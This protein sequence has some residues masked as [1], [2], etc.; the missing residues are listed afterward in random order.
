MATAGV[1][2]TLK[3][4]LTSRLAPRGLLVLLPVLIAAG[5]GGIHRHPPEVIASLQAEQRVLT[6]KLPADRLRLSDPARHGLTALAEPLGRKRLR[7]RA[8][9]TILLQFTRV[10]ACRDSSR[11]T[12][13]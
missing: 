3:R 8:P 12:R 7:Q 4:A 1:G 13:A 2:S 11:P 6:S 9:P 10:S 5:A